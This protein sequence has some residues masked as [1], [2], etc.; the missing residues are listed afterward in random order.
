ML[1]ASQHGKAKAWVR[2][3]ILLLSDA[4]VVLCASYAAVQFRFFPHIPSHYM[5]IYLHYLPYLLLSY[6]AVFLLGG[7]YRVLWG[8]AGNYDILRLALICAVSAAATLGENVIFK[9]HASQMVLP[10]TGILT[11]FAC[12][13]ARLLWRTYRTRFRSGTHR[14]DRNAAPVLIVGA[15]EGATH[16]IQHCLR[17]PQVFGRPALMVDDDVGKRNLRIQ[18]VPV[19][20]CLADIP[21][22]VE[23]YQIRTIIISIQHLNGEKFDSL[24]VTCN[25]TRCQVLTLSYR[26]AVQGSAVSLRKLDTSDFL[27]RDEVRTNTSGISAYLE[28]RIVFVTGGGGSI[29]SELCRQVM[30]FSP[31]RL[32]IYDAYENGAYDLLCEL[33]QEYG[34][35]CP[36]D[37]VIG[38]IQDIRRLE[39]MIGKYKPDV[40][41]HA[42]AHKHVPLMED[43]PSEAVKNNVLGT[44]NVLTVASRMGVGKF[45][46][47]STDKAVN[48]A[49][50]MGATKRA[51]EM[52]VQY[53]AART[54]MKCMA[55]RFGNVLGSNGSVIPL[56]EAQI[57]KGGPVTVTHAEMERY[58]MTIPEAAQLVLQAGSLAS[59][60]SIYILDMGKPVKIMDLAKKLIRLHG[61]TPGADM[62]IKV[63]GLRPGEKLH[64]DLMMDQ[65]ASAAAR[66][67]HEK[68]FAAP[69]ILM[70]DGTFL[71]QLQDL[72]HSLAGSDWDVVQALSRI[73]PTYNPPMRPQWL[74]KNE[75]EAVT[76]HA[77]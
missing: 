26:R 21:K 7:V 30:R 34:P 27:P 63:V 60:G 38:S 33:R 15:G 73:V 77:M 39:I 35:D 12:C 11:A 5:A 62:E 56:F 49:N 76:G 48:P 47:I 51:A 25:S 52:L 59:K 8:H 69:A 57:R 36:L 37:V 65:E 14:A 10:L 64:E 23:A 31:A 58:F 72:E 32:V 61:Y 2:K 42:A 17:D 67:E 9:W 41:F 74:S 50:V 43:N 66:T 13:G 70:L 20:G 18:G 3:G 46:A 29:G 44:R 40:V 1:N 53:Y 55:V 75:E 24:L 19:R 4:A 54:P 71:K 45:V 16:V 22:L 28:G 68:I 6:M